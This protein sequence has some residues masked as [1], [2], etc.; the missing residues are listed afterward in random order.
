MSKKRSKSE[1]DEDYLSEF[2]QKIATQK[3]E[4]LEERRRDLQRVRKGFIGTLAGIVLAGLIGWILLN[5]RFSDPQS[6][7]IPVI[8]RQITPAKIQP[9]NPGGMEILNQ[10]KSI[11]DLVEKK[12]G[13]T[14]KVES[15]L[16]QP[17]APKLPEIVPQPEPEAE[18]EVAEAVEETGK[19]V[20]E[21]EEKAL[22]E[23]IEAVQ[24]NSDKKIIIPEKPKDLIVKAQTTEPAPA[25]PQTQAPE[26]TLPVTQPATVKSGSWQVQIMASSNKN[27][28]EKGWQTLTGKHSFLKPLP[29]EIETVKTDAG[30]IIYRLKTGAFATRVDA[31]KICE[32]LKKAGSSCLVKQK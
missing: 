17:E 4:I 31:E 27:A 23:L 19:S 20:N 26:K 13:E 11:Y 15:I 24:T 16:P 18:P 28:I 2:R 7:E 12:T 22:E 10:D 8:R 14:A 21:L 29:H 6:G 1:N 30:S 32:Q 5:P 9:A 25:K 3:E